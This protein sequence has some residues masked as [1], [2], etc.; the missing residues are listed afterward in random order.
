MLIKSKILA[1]DFGLVRTGIAITDESGLMAFPRCTVHNPPQT[2]RHVFFDRLLQCI[3]A[4]NPA[5]LVVGLPLYA[6]G[7]ESLT[8]KQVRN[9]VARLQRRTPLPIYLMPEFLSSAAAADD[10]HMCGVYKKKG[11]AAKALLDQQ[12]AVHILQSFLGDSQQEKRRV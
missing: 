4:E 9:F 6:D 3:Q 7:C 1:I 12:A 2:P 10:L 5:A 11:K 8:T